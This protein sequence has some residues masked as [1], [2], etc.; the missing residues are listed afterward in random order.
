[1][2]PILG[3]GDRREK[4]TWKNPE[5]TAGSVTAYFKYGKKKKKKSENFHGKWDTR[6]FLISLL[7]MHVYK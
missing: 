5:V 6:F 3:R 7:K 4:R 1:M 2:V